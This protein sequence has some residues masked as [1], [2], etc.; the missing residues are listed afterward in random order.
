MENKAVAITG[1]TAGVGR[2]TA[3]AFAK[4]GY[5]VGIMARGHD[6]LDATRRELEGMGVRV[7]TVECDVVDSKQV[8]SAAE[9]I[10]NELGPINV[11]IN[12]AMTTIFSEFMD[13]SAEEFNRVT[14]VDY[15]GFVNGTRAALKR[16][17]KRNSGTIVQVG[18]ALAYRGIPLQTAYCGAKHAIQGFTEALRSELI[19]NKSKIH[20]TMVQMPALNTPQFSWCKNNLPNKPQPVPPIYQPEVAARAIVYAALHKEREVFVGMMNNVI[21]VGNCFFPGV[22]DYYLGKTGFK[23]Q[24]TNQPDDKNRP[25]N[26]WEP[27]KGDYGAHGNFD[28]KAK[29]TA[30]KLTTDFYRAAI[31][32]SGLLF[33]TL[34]V[35]SVKKLAG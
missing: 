13:M 15:L 3:R 21:I 18:S 33:L 16:M 28:D 7:S 32:F 23:S 1:G 8:D 9:K 24:Q 14:E 34:A 10:E 6:S 30:I 31:G 20:I 29:D 11:W 4:M 17:N 25:N 35:F 19:H 12:D 22:G 26:L 2:A 27:L 5:N